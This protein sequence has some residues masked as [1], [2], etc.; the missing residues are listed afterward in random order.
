MEKD[1]IKKYVPY[2]FIII[3]LITSYFIIRPYITIFLISCIIAYTFYPIYKLTKKVLKN[4]II[5]ALFVS[6]LTIFILFITI[7]FI[8]LGV[9]GEALNTYEH[10]KENFYGEEGYLNCEAE[11]NWCDRLEN[12]SILLNDE[13]LNKYIDIQKTSNEIYNM[14]FIRI[15]KV[16]T[17]IP[18][19]FINFTIMIF[20]MY[21]LFKDGKRFIEYISNKLTLTKK[22]HEILFTKIDDTAKSII[23]GSLIIAFI[24]GFVGFIGYLFLGIN[25]PLLW[26]LA[27]AF[28][29]LIPIFGTA[30]IW[31]PQATYIILTGLDDGGW[32]KGMILLGYGFFII[33]GVDNILRPVM[34]GKKAKIHP[35]IILL[36]VL[37]GIPL[38][39]MMGIIIGPLILGIFITIFEFTTQ[40]L[41]NKNI[42]DIKEVEVNDKIKSKKN[43]HKY[44]RNSNSTNK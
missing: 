28:F 37:G 41:N 18:K 5:S 2:V 40:D 36:G 34:L 25:S 32:I 39:G 12:I 35:V 33:G 3:I 15:K 20:I 24:Q 8:F 11:N 4:K 27:V 17:S 14:I 29:S 7:A 10:I 31:F 22:D 26:G 6:F 16:F 42:K 44:R 13:N 38:F 19:I 21:Y 43:R 30:I 9:Y 1:L 23:F